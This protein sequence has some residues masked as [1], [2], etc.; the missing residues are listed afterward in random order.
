MN[1]IEVEAREIGG[2]LGVILPRELVVRE[3]I[4][5]HEKITIRV[6]KAKPLGHFFGTTTWEASTEKM[7]EEIKKGWK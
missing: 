1:D 4:K 5:P 6:R 2:S 7:I 3:H